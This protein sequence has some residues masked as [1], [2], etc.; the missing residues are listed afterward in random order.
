MCG[1]GLGALRGSA[2]F[3]LGVRRHCEETQCGGYHEK[4][5]AWKSNSFENFEGPIRECLEGYAPIHG[6]VRLAHALQER[7][8]GTSDA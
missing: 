3:C 1:I 6:S 4:I 2:H 5:D 7:M 8:D